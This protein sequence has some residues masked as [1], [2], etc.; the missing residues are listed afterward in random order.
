MRVLL[1]PTGMQCAHSINKGDADMIDLAEWLQ[2]NFAALI[3]AA[4]EKLSSDE[5]LRSSVEESI[6]VF[7][8]G[9][10]HCARVKSMIPL[11]AILIDWIEARSAP[12]DEEPAGL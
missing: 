11:H 6:A 7:Y 12:T 8:D 5:Q 10:I 3:S 9:V 4:S 2:A 1:P